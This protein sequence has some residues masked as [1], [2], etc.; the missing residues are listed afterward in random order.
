MGSGNRKKS[1][2]SRYVSFRQRAEGRVARSG[3]LLL[4]SLILTGLVL[5]CGP[6][7][8]VVIGHG[9]DA[10]ERGVVRHT[11]N[12][13]V[14]RYT[15]TPLSA[16]QVTVEFGPTTGYG[17]NTWTVADAGGKP[18]SIFVAGMRADTRYHMRAVVHFADGTTLNDMDHVFTSGHYKKRLLPHMTV[19]TSGTPEPGVELINPWVGSCAQAIVTDLKGNVLWAYNY[20]DRQSALTVLTHKY[21]HA[22]YLT[23]QGWGNWLRKLFGRRASG[24]PT[25]WDAKLWKL[26]PRERRFGTIIYPIKPLANGDFLM[27]IGL[28][29]HALLD[30]PMGTVPPHTTQALREINLAG[31][32]VRN[33]T[34]DELNERLRATGYHG[35]TL[36]IMHHDFVMLPNGHLI[37]IAN[38]TRVYTDLPGYPGATRVIGD[39]LVELDGN[40]KPVWTWSEFDHLDVNR[41]PM[42]FPDWTHTNA[43][44]YTKDDGNLLVSMRSQHWVIKIDYE[45]GHGSGKILWRLGVGGDFRMV[46]GNSPTDWNYGQHEPVV[47]SDTATGADRDAGVFDLG[48]M[49][50]G[51]DRIMPDGKVCGKPKAPACYTTVPIFRIDEKAKTATLVFQDVFPKV[52]SFC[53]GGVQALPNGDVEIDMGVSH[54]HNS[55]VYEVTRAAHPQVVWH[56]HAARTNLYR[57]ERLPSFYPGVQWGLGVQAHASAPPY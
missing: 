25:L 7:K 26:P 12:A 11:R 37:V 43:V 5:G 2:I 47:F 10:M 39:I 49:D 54:G 18:A 41:H 9:P 13:Q 3:R 38:G 53:C 34:V 19:Q 30:G 33:L 48:M 15:I 14:A 51:N 23:L 56:L 35:P 31:E 57:T 21:L 22:G 45:N 8:P 16:A 1:L 24:T 29:S 4:S 17:L 44:V 55:D 36:E 20:S 40:W 28:P 42:D 46:N 50:N 6:R 27:V 52:F 32:T